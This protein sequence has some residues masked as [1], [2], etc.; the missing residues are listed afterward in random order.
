M[1]LRLALLQLMRKHAAL[2]A[3]PVDPLMLFTSVQQVLTVLQLYRHAN[4]RSTLDSLGHDDDGD[5]VQKIR[6]FEDVRT[7]VKHTSMDGLDKRQPSTFSSASLE[8]G[9]RKCTDF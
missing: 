9:E 5:Y 6:L 8:Q 7:G 1:A 2:R 4:S 3:R